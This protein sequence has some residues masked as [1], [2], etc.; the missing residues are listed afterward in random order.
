MTR[1]RSC[2]PDW[3]NAKL[4]TGK[5]IIIDGPMGT[6]LEARGVPMHAKAW[7][8]AAIISHPEVVRSTHADYVRAG[9]QV[10]ITN[11]FSAG[12]HMLE[13]AGLGDEVAAINKRAVELAQEAR[14]EAGD[15]PVAIAGSICDWVYT[16]SKWRDPKNLSSSLHE[17][18]ELLADAGVDLIALEM[19][20]NEVGSP[21]AIEAA[22]KT[23]LPVWL[24]LSC[25]SDPDTGR[26]VNFDIP[27]LVFEDWVAKLAMCEVCLINVM[28]SPIQDTAKGLAVVK[29]HWQGPIGA[30][31]ESGYFIMPN[32]Q[33]VDV[34]A[35]DELVREAQHWVSA[36]VQVLGGC[37]GLSP[38]H[39][40]AL[41]DAFAWNPDR[42]LD[43]PTI[44][45]QLWGS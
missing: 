14:D 45:L 36:G 15:L 34:I 7:S 21:L 37:C 22:L 17:Q 26:L 38:Q 3:L 11:T 28:H 41:R 20:E 23:G 39:I 31:P 24:G 18:A 16:D 25:K 27:H 9:A 33:F 35:P 5:I 42:G 2:G 19:S 30:Y 1:L 44:I 40:A 6:E 13:P 29:Q 43:I 12:R 4:D 32:W 8:A 10:I